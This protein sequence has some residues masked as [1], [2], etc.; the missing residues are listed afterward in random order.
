MNAFGGDEFAVAFYSRYADWESKM[1]YIQS[2]I[3][4]ESRGYSVNVGGALW[5]L[6]GESLEACYEVADARLY[7]NKRRRKLQEHA[8]HV[9]WEDLD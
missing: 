1:L 3:E 5:G 7:K 9:S 8:S 4:R 6:D 2:L